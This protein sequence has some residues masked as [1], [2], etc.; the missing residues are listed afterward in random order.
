M[1]GASTTTLT[2]LFKRYYG[3]GTPIYQQNLKSWLLNNIPVSSERPGGTGRFKAT[4]MAGNEAGG[5]I[6]EQERLADAQSPNPEQPQITPKVTHWSFEFTGLSLA[7]SQGQEYAFANTAKAVMSDALQRMGSDRNRQ[8]FGDGNGIL[9]QVN[10]AVVANTVITVDDV[11]YFRRNMILDIFQVL[12]GVKEAS[13]V[14]V[15]AINI[16]TNQITVNVNVT[17]SD[18]AI[19]VKTAVQDAP[20]ADGK[21]LTG[22]ARIV[23]TTT[24][25]TIF[26]GI[27]RSVNTEY[28]SN[29]INAG[30]VP[31]SQA[32]LQRLMNRIMI[33]GGDEP[34]KIVSRHGVYASFVNTA[35]AQTRYQD[36][37]VKAGHVKLTWNG[38]EWML[39]KDCQTGTLYMLNM[40]VDS[41]ARYV[42]QEPDLAALDTAEQK[43][44]HR[45]G[46]D[47]YYG[48]YIGYDNIGSDKPNNHGK[49]INLTE[50]LF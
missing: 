40:K 2:A 50:P 8:A 44:G 13:A 16:N 43:I 39:D 36:D 38:L 15:T 11:Q 17:V 47:K 45:E 33:I 26:Q 35:L 49:L 7:V 34:T 4:Y 10:G 14:R 25:G 31:L 5:A 41:L 23:D 9:T 18:N 29:V 6:N 19:I 27:D 20:P 48:Y 22:L 37:V 3:K 42:V 30:A 1:A 21:E 24:A 46:Y 12:G 32:L 28:Q